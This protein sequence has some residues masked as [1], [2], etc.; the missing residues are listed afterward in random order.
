MP[1]IFESIGVWGSAGCYGVISLFGGVAAV[2]TIITAFTSWRSTLCRLVKPSSNPDIQLSDAILHLL[3][4]CP[5]YGTR[6]I[7][8]SGDMA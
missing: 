8:H 7:N 5:C 1:C 3:F 6:S 2:T 4:C